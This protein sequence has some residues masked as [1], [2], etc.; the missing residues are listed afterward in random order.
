M[1]TVKTTPC[2][3]PARCCFFAPESAQSDERGVQERAT[4][5]SDKPR[6]QACSTGGGSAQSGDWG[7]P[8]QRFRI[9]KRIF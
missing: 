7:V 2:H 9:S 6:R 5:G 4:K 1:L 3:S 8:N